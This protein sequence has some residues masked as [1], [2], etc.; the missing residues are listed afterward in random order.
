MTS[1]SMPRPAS[2]GRAWLDL[3]RAGN[4]PSVWSNVLAALVLSGPLVQA[5]DVPAASMM[6]W[7]PPPGLWLAATLAATLAYAGG[8][9]LND[10][11]DAT[12]DGRHRPDR[13]IPSGLVTRTAAAWGGGLLLASGVAAFVAGLGA[14]PSWAAAMA[15]AIV[16]Y[17]W[18]H[19][20]WAG[21]VVLM[22]ACRAFLGLTVASV[23]GQAFTTAVLIWAGALS[24][25]IVGVSVIAR[26]EYWPG[27][28]AAV[29]G[30]WVGRLLRAMPWLDA[31]A[32]ALV[33]AWLPAVASA[34]AVPL[35]RAA[36]RRAA[37][38]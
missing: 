3:A 34:M 32:M 38:T 31:A 12:F 26:A 28:P 37:S 22:A 30:R 11:F 35:G 14:S 5:A 4:F 1:P 15:A 21:S 25:Y 24:L 36:Q 29:L 19:K 33:G 6:A 8:A 13:A 23:P 16:A 10:V 20:R 2:R 9:T 27:A 18:V 7:W 17:D